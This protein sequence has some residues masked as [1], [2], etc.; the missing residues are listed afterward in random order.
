MFCVS[1]PVLSEQRMSTPA[2]SSTV[3]SLVTIA[4]FAARARAPRAMVT[5]ST[6]GMATGTAAMVRTRANWS[7]SSSLSPR[8]TATTNMSMASTTA[9]T[10][11]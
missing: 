8:N 5:D 10:R 6:A 4:C 11:R 2:S 3:D 9:M 7:T 1:V